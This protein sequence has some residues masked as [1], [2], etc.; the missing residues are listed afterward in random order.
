MERGY[1]FLYIAPSGGK[2]K[3]CAK[4]KAVFLNVLC[5]KIV[6]DSLEK[7]NC[8]NKKFLKILKI[9]RPEDKT[10]IDQLIE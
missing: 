1:I 10:K 4:G 9:L 7:L 2:L 6:H 3:N 5:M 8:K